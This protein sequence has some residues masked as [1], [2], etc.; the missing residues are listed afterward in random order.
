MPIKF[1][2]RLFLVMLLVSVAYTEEFSQWSTPTNLGS[3]INSAL[4]D[5]H[6]VISK[7]GLSF[8]FGS[9]RRGGFGGLDIYVAQRQRIDDPWGEPQNLGPAINT[10]YDEGGPFLST[11]G[12]SL[13]FSSTRQDLGYGGNDL[14]V[15]RRRHTHDDFAWESPR[16]LGSTINTVYN[17]ASGSLF[18]ADDAT[19]TATLYFASN[20]PGGPGPVTDPAGGGTDIYASSLQE[21]GRLG[22]ATLVSEFNTA[23]IDRTPFVRRDGLEMFLVSNRQGTLG[24]FDIWV[25][26]RA[27]TTEPWSPPTNI[28]SAVNS[29]NDEG[30]PTLS[31]D[32]ISLYFQSSRPGGVG[33][34]DLYVTTRSR[35][36]ENEVRNEHSKE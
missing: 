30:R 18:E 24:G 32:S 11:D 14:Y 13:Y 33:R 5:F 12:H 17:E 34:L 28:G 2:T 3:P 26:K 9:N 31:F 25:S 6:G 22:P 4:G 16:N 19:G 35:L 20:R 7:D 36:K 29:A 27:T 1:W 8:Y 10:A 23:D 15:S 21:D